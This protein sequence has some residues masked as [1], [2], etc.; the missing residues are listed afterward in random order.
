M[1]YVFLEYPTRV[2]DIATEIIRV[3]NDYKA[4]KIDNDTLKT[5]VFFHYATK[6]P[7]MLFDGPGN[8]N[9]TI[10]KMIGRR[11]SHKSIR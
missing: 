1:K 7:E 2:K 8:L 5:F 11:E 9:P 4:R 3:S 6:Y 10:T